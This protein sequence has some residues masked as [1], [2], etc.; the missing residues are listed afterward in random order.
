MTQT[1]AASFI[2][3]SY[4]QEDTITEAVQSLLNQKCE[5]IEIII[6]D[7][8]ST[9][10]TF[11][12]IQEVIKDYRGPHPVLA[13]R[14]EVNLG[15]NRHIARSVSLATSDL[16]IWAAGD[17]R[18]APGRAQKVIDSYRQTGAKLIYSDAETVGPDK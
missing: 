1:P 8:A 18:N 5:P 7:D 16:M 12:K 6:S 4:C 15:L 11:E 14:N 17:D 10:G 13:R 2:L 9:D 3:L